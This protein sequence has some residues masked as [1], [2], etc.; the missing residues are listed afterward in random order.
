MLV[1][2]Q[3]SDDPPTVSAHEVVTGGWERGSMS[4]PRTKEAVVQMGAGCHMS[5]QGA[6]SRPGHLP[7]HAGLRGGARALGQCL[8]PQRPAKSGLSRSSKSFLEA[9]RAFK[10]LAAMGAVGPRQAVERCR[11]APT[12]QLPSPGATWHTWALLPIQFGPVSFCKQ[13]PF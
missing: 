8:G 13:L 9:T 4:T 11:W 3:G 10:E 6:C 5:V 12:G 2:E 7:S 1:R